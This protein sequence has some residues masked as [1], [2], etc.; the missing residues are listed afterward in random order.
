MMGIDVPTLRYHM[1]RLYPLHRGAIFHLNL[2]NLHNDRHYV[3]FEDL[4][5]SWRP[6]GGYRASPEGVRVSE[7]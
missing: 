2:R 6:D 3:N 4:N 7:Y 5:G 1:G